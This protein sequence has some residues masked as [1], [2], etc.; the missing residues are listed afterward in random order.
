MCDVQLELAFPSRDMPT[1]LQQAKVLHLNTNNKQPHQVSATWSS[2]WRRNDPKV[3]MGSDLFVLKG[4]QR[5]A[6]L[7]AQQPTKRPRPQPAMSAPFT[8]K[9]L[10]PSPKFSWPLLRSIKKVSGAKFY[11]KGGRVS[12]DDHLLIP[13]L[14]DLERCNQQI[15]NARRRGVTTEAMKKILETLTQERM[16]TLKA[17]Q[18]QLSVAQFKKLRRYL[19]P[20]AKDIEEVGAPIAVKPRT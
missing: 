12:L 20:L 16:K 15:Q 11:A 2:L 7:G 1:T 8:R 5:V 18:S 14:S 6:A 10:P 19:R 17:A 4:Q 3:P 13:F 9:L